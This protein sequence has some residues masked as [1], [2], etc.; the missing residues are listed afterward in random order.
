[1]PKFIDWECDKCGDVRRTDDLPDSWVLANV[2]ES[3]FLGLPS[4]PY[5]WCN[6]CWKDVKS[7][8]KD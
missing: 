3:A 8:Q 2:I 6:L 7:A 4:R 5:V 1:M